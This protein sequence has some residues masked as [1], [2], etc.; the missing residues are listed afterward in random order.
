MRSRILVTRHNPARE[1]L[2]GTPPSLQSTTESRKKST[3]Y[4]AKTREPCCFGLSVHQPEYMVMD[5]KEGTL[6]R[7]LQQMSLDIIADLRVTEL[8]HRASFTSRF[9]RTGV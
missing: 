2:F 6:V 7:K 4:S 5:A 8:N 3:V 9:L 1:H